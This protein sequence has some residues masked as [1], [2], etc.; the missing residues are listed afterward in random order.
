M[1][2]AKK[3]F[4]PLCPRVEE[5]KLMPCGLWAN[6]RDMDLSDLYRVLRA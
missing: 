2:V 5:L 3:I 6:V 1:I 4:K